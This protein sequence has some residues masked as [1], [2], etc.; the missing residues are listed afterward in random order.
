MWNNFSDNTGAFPKLNNMEKN[1]IEGACGTQLE[2]SFTISSTWMLSESKPDL[3]G[4]K[5]LVGFHKSC[6]RIIE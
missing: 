4:Q 2:T 5:S 3:D 6:Q 1:D